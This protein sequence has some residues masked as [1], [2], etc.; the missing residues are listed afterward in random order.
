MLTGGTALFAPL[1]NRLPKPDDVLLCFHEKRLLLLPQNGEDFSFPSLALLEAV[2][3][4]DASPRFLF[5]LTNRNVYALDT[6][7]PLS[8]SPESK[9]SYVEIDVFRR[10]ASSCDALSL[11][12]AWHLIIWYR[13]NR[14]CGACGTLLSDSPS[15]R[16]LCC[17]KCRQTIYPTISPAVSVA[18]TSGESILLARNARSAFPHFSLVAGYVEVGEALEETVQRE[19]WE[20]V[21]LRVKNIRYVASQ[22]WGLSQAEMI[23][24]HAELD[25]SDEITLQESELS[26]ARWFHKRELSPNPNPISLSFDMIEKFRSGEL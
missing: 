2:L 1:Y 18:I 14:F 12:S 13:R 15:E 20:E 16:A 9:L 26:E 21:G 23:G 17:P 8:L 22:P 25:G 24:F 4:A 11:L 10:L 7:A 6:N 19:V 5:S 3:P